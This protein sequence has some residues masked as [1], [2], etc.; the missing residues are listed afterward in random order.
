MATAKSRSSVATVSCPSRKVPSGWLVLVRDFL[1]LVGVLKR[2]T[3]LVTASE[4]HVEYQYFLRNAANH[5]IGL[6]QTET[7]SRH[8]VEREKMLM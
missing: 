2:L 4:H 3:C 8:N 5:Y 7:V 6:A 1:P